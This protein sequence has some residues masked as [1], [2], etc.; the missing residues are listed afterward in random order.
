MLRLLTAVE[1]E[2]EWIRMSLRVRIEEVKG[3]IEGVG[4]MLGFRWGGI[5][6]LCAVMN[7]S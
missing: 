6:Q 2:N 5:Q 4:G 7:A 1:V 3:G